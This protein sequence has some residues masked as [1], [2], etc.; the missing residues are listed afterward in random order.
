[1]KTRIWRDAYG[2]V[3]YVTP[4]LGGYDVE[5]RRGSRTSRRTC[6]TM[7]AALAYMGARGYCWQEVA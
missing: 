6:R 4:T 2:S 1:M 7:A 3:A 5:V